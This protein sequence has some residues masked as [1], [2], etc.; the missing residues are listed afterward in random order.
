MDDNFFN[1]GTGDDAALIRAPE[2]P[3]YLV[4]TIDYFR[5]FVKD[6]YLFGQIAAIHA[7][8][9]IFA[10]N[11]EP[12]SAM[13]LCVLPYGPEDKVEDTLVQM[14]GG[15][16]KVLTDEKC[17]LVGG[18]TAEGA[19]D[20]LGLSCQGVVHPDK[21]LPKGPI[22]PNCSLIITKPIGTG[23]I[24]AGDMKCLVRGENVHTALNSML[25][26]NKKASNILFNN[27]CKSCTDVTG[28]G[29]FGHLLEMMK[30][31]GTGSAMGVRVHLDSVPLLPGAAECVRQGVFSTLQPQVRY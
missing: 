24:M 23:V 14:L 13:A 6:P 17:T 4:Q 15:A 9:D 25:V 18:H 1:C 12:I 8:S 28:F 3:A 19:E 31:D 2:P 5:S 27:G 16:V 26:S 10:M 30:Y 29:V 20:A 11:A 22:A 7:L 21:V